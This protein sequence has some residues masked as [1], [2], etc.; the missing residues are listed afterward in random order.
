MSRIPMS[1]NT[2]ETNRLSWISTPI[3]AAL[4]ELHPHLGRSGR[5]YGDEIYV[6]K[7]NVD[8]EEN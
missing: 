6:Y 3:G 2:R 1:G 8:K 7:I 5:G 4:A